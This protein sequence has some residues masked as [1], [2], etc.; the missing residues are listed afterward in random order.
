MKITNEN[1]INYAALSPIDT[2]IYRVRGGALETLFLSENIPDLLGMT[3]EEYLKITEKDAMD[4]ALP[5][6]REAL[7]AAT[8]E[9]IA[10]GG[11]LDH[12]YRVYSNKKGFEWVHVDA[13]V[14]GEM[15]SDTVII[16][17]FANISREGNIFE[18]IL[19]NSDRMT[20][21]VERS[22]YEVLYANE[23]ILNSRYFEGKSMLDLKCYS[24]LR[25]RACPCEDCFEL[26]YEDREMHERYSYDEQMGR[27]SLVTWKNVGWC[28]RESVII[29]IKDV[30]E[31]KNNEISL[32][33][34]NQM[35]QSAIEDAKEMMW[36]Y[37]PQ[38]KT[39]TYQIDNPYTKM[40]CEKLGMPTVI[41]DVPESLIGMVDD[42]YKDGFLE[43]FSLD[44]LDKDG[45]SFEY[46]SNVNGQ[47][48]W[49]RV[50]SRPIYDLNNEI[51]AVFCSGLNITQEKQAESN[52]CSLVEQISDIK[53]IG[54]S[55]FRL[56]LSQNRFV[57]GYSIY[58][59]LNTRLQ[60][61]T[62]DGHFETALNEISDEEIRDRLL[63]KYTCS[64]LISKYN[65]GIRR[66]D[67]EYPV[68]SRLEAT[69]GQLRWVKA[70]NNLIMNPDTGDI[71]DITLVTEVTRQKQAEKILSIMASKG[72]DYIGLIDVPMET[73]DIFDGIWEHKV[74]KN[75]ESLDYAAA[76][77]TLTD[78]HVDPD[79]IEAFT[80]QTAVKNIA[81]R[82][83]EE[84]EVLIHYDFISDDGIRLKKQIKCKWL[85][86]DKR[87]ILIV[88]DDITEAY[89]Q[90]QKR[91]SELQDALHQAEVANNAKSEFVSRISH[92]IRT[93]ISAII[94]MTD[95]A[96]ED[97]DD[98]ER[99]MA[100][101]EN[102]SSSNKF[103]M[104]LINDILD[105]SK[106]DSGKIELYP[107]P[108]P[109]K[110]YIDKIN[111]MFRPLCEQKGL[112][113]KIEVD[114]EADIDTK[115]VGV[116]DKVRFDQVTM[117]LLSN[118]IKFTPQG[119]TVTYTSQSSILSDE[120]IRCRY[121]VSDTGIGMSED[122]QRT[123]FDPFSQEGKVLNA[124]GSGTGLGLAI[125][126]RIVDL[127]GG[128]IEVESSPGEGTAI[129]VTMVLPRADE[130]QIKMMTGAEQDEDTAGEG[131][132]SG[133]VLLAEDNKINTEIALRLLGQMGLE[134]D[135]AGNGEEAAAA[136]E[137]S[138][139][140]EYSAILMDIQM[141][142]MDGYTSAEKI[143]R[144]ERADA[145]TVPIIAMTAD[146][147]AEA[148]KHS[149]E[150]GMNE[151]ITKPIDVKKLRATLLKYLG[152]ENVL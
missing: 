36:M 70:V 77:R 20:I 58:P 27:W 142:V 49:W 83:E 84:P 60:T 150:A 140:G 96:K 69:R 95:F 89:I 116:V 2:A 21:V 146:A 51:K 48:N 9:T 19:D 98:K 82:L 85:D 7:T 127:M 144:M 66:I 50:T 108:Y 149:R 37:D 130:E 92:D 121:T 46:S 119:G 12:Y 143:R 137:H 57:S 61:K 90:E 100:D 40:I 88:Q 81:G 52:Y 31:E 75:G 6:D 28:G 122:F 53:K 115:A 120:K 32:D 72:C 141:P 151:H 25:G 34:M 73:V 97:I 134:T 138:A 125:V 105:I 103:L 148:V 79:E 136:F 14:C 22:S 8:L 3:R 43:M 18:M 117:N 5:Q 78:S 87:E 15:D 133:K 102:I 59:E 93:P 123:M 94:G 1:I 112:K 33:K 107:E 44:R 74:I 131:L 54:L 76:L 128:T 113:F 63:K 4:L 67:D 65:Q 24:L 104:S 62:A 145:K 129:T 110:E 42:E 47:K 71:E 41:E 26:A 111:S 55:S 139:E 56:N 114:G 109:F 106:I 29:Y 16:A 11:K 45:L 135:H 64:E 35:Y 124:H 126:N 86:N 91:L 17:R 132:M 23:K 13:H 147:F 101:I 30:T 118:A 38:K 68:R 10:N 39:V 80:E 99:L 152:S